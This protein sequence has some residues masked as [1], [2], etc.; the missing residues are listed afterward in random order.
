M[1][2]CSP[3]H[4]ATSTG[5]ENGDISTMC[6]CAGDQCAKIRV[7]EVQTR[8]VRYYELRKSIIISQKVASSKNCP[9]RLFSA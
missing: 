5:D 7:R 9:Y 1:R 2:T 3:R 4:A 6:G 8:D